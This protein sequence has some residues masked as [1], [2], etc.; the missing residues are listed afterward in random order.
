[1]NC[2][3]AR[4]LIDQ[5]VKP[6]SRH[7]LRAALGFHLAKCPQCRQYQQESATLLPTLLLEAQPD[8][9]EA[10]AISALASLPSARVRP[11]NGKRYRKLALAS[12]GLLLGVPLIGLLWVAAILV[13]AD[14]NLQA[15]IVATPVPEVVA[16]PYSPDGAQPDQTPPLT[17]TLAEDAAETPTTSLVTLAPS[18]DAQPEATTDSVARV[19][20]TAELLPAPVVGAP[21]S[22]ALTP[23][24][25][26]GAINVLVL[27]NDHRPGETEVPR[28]DVI[29]LIRVDP[30]QER[31]VLL[32]LV[33]DLW[34]DIPGYGY[35]RI[36]AA[37]RTGEIYG[38]PGSGL[39]TARRT[40]SNLLGVP[41]DYVVMVDFQG[42][43]GLIDT[44]GGITVDVEKE[45]Y[46]DA[47]PT[48]DYGYQVAHFVPGPEQMD[49]NR[50]LMYSRI[51]HPDSDFMRIR[52]QQAVAVA[53][54]ARLRERG[55]LQNILAIDQI[56]GALVGYVQTDMPR[57][58]IIGLVWAFRSYDLANIEQYTVTVDM[59]T[60]GVGS[61]LYA[62]VPNPQAIEQLARL[63]R[64]A[65]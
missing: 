20:P 34:V 51:R 33:R 36:N 35:D 65:P 23:P 54:G 17:A 39:L 56:T 55:D 38:A 63:F 26:G 16:A 40:V 31:I 61:D 6:G 57:D 59:V 32:S 30:Q 37:Y 11:A 13:R 58:R 3:E 24:P 10:A 53:V 42:F 5:G 62:L 64:G 2:S 60:A 49:G 44:L 14:R 47:F 9:R 43:I 22:P 8:P 25:A 27:G 1:M 28:T 7:P 18:P 50:A 29:M 21:V 48:M 41:I 19:W 45:L 46:D 52:R 12:I 4:S 15:M